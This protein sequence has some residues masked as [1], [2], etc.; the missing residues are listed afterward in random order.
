MAKAIVLINASFG[1]ENAILCELKRIQNIT[2]LYKIYG[3][4]D[5]LAKVEAESLDK[6][7]EI[8]RYKFRRIE[9][10]KSTIT[11]IVAQTDAITA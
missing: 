1:N 3:V 9:G 4:Y 7:K 10:I 11:M 2:E 6:I 5:I 8:T